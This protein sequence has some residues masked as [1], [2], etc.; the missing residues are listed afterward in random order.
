MPSQIRNQIYEENRWEFRMLHKGSK[1]LPFPSA[2]ES[3][4]TNAILG[5]GPTVL[6][7]LKNGGI[8]AFD[9]MNFAIHPKLF[10]LIVSLFHSPVTNPKHA[11]LLM[12]THDMFVCEELRADQVWFAAKNEFGI[13]ELYSAQDFEDASIAMPFEAWY[14]AGRFGA[15]PKFG[16][17]NYIATGDEQ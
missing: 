8:L 11:Q 10:S 12:T 15:L 4:G 13:S 2:L 6:K 1:L 9:E 3:T 5:V 17:I 16:N 7:V 14:R